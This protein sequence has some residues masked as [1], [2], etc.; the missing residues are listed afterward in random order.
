VTSATTSK[1]YSLAGKTGIENEFYLYKERESG[2]LEFIDEELSH[3]SVFEAQYNENTPK[4]HY[5][6]TS[7]IC[8]NKAFTVT[9]TVNKEV[10][11]FSRYKT[12]LSTFQCKV[13]K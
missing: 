8:N 13:E 12:L 10:T 5:I 9:I 3:V 7:R 1:Q 2:D 6:Q 11:D 4:L